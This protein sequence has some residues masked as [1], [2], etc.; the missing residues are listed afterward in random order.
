MRIFFGFGNSQLFLA[1]LA[2]DFSKNVVQRLRLKR[3]RTIK[4]FVVNRHGDKVHLRLHLAI[5]PVKVIEKK[6]PRQLS[7]AIRA[8]VEK[9]N[10][11]AIPNP[12]LVRMR[13]DQRLEEFVGLPFLIPLP[14][15]VLR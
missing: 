15:G 11:V 6:R 5:E 3:D 7:S 13:K 14:D 12:L 4:G 8:K 1:R 10:H 2:D 9:E